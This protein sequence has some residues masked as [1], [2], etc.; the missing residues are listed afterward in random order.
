MKAASVVIDA[1]THAWRQWP[2]DPPV[3]DHESRGRVEQLLWEM[4]G[5]GV[6]RAVLVCANITHNPDNNGYVAEC[7]ARYPERLVQFADVDCMWS[8]T[9]H[10]PGAAQRLRE[11]AA[12]YRLRG[13]T[14]YVTEDVAWLD[15]DE[16]LAFFGA[17]ADL[18]LIA[19]LALPPSWQAGLRRLAARFPTLPI[20]CHHMGLAKAACAAEI[21]AVCRSAEQPNIYVKLSGYHYAAARGWEYPFGDVQPYVQALLAHFGPE[22]LCWGSDYPVARFFVTYQQTL[23]ALRSHCVG[24]NAEQVA[25]ILGGNMQR[26][27]AG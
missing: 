23:E 1:H 15:S 12:R 9:Y 19:S 17:A 6:Q 22:R 11:A 5:N 20:L 27:L 24:L 8:E 25:A 26:L 4:D 13:F 3:P 2:Y 10:R 16:G 7:V 14:H 21:D 18:G